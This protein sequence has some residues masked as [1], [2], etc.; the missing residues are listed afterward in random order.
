MKNSVRIISFVMVVLL[1]GSLI[2]CGAAPAAEPAAPEASTQAPAAEPQK[3]EAPAE[4]PA[5]ENYM[6]K[7]VTVGQISTWGLLCPYAVTDSYSVF[8]YDALYEKLVDV[9]G[10]YSISPRAAASWDVNEDSSEYTIHLNKDLKW[11]DGTPVTAADWVFAAQTVT[12]PD[13][14]S[15]RKSIFAKFANTDGDGNETA[16]DSV[17]WEAVDDY[18]LRITLKAPEDF[19]AFFV[20]NNNGIYP[21]PQHLLK[22]IPTAELLENAYWQNP[23]GCGVGIFDSQVE[24][25]TITFNTNQDYYRGAPQFGKL[26]FRVVSQDS[27]AASFMAGE[28]DLCYSGLNAVDALAAAENSEVELAATNVA[29]ALCWMNINVGKL[30]DVRL[31]QAV[32]YCIDQNAISQILWEGDGVISASPIVQ[33]GAYYTDSVEYAAEYNVEKAKALFDEAGWNYNDTFII[34]TPSGTRETAAA[35]IQQSL[36]SIGVKCEIQSGDATTVFANAKEGNYDV[37]LQSTSAWTNDPLT[38]RNSINTYVHGYQDGEIGQEL[39]GILDEMAS[40]QDAAKRA[41]LAKKW[42]ERTTELC[43]IACVYRTR[44]YMLTSA[45]VHGFDPDSQAVGFNTRYHELV[46]D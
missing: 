1:V 5:A 24:G 34:G 38:T 20:A 22:D 37:S 43:P 42:L 10:D 9:N 31:R 29:A 28:L 14:V 45:R 30:S 27:L 44:Q 36:L 19:T 4:E 15:G 16:E 40:E 46:I 17:A 6:D 13:F 11:H 21:L 39:N 26:V 3:T 7:V 8:V 2:G 41:E 35:V 18:T 12:D 33:T 23:V 25:T 32:R